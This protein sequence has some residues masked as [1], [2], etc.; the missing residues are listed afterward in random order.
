M[1]AEEQDKRLPLPVEGIAAIRKK[2]S[3]VNLDPDM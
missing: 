3:L 1:I 2:N